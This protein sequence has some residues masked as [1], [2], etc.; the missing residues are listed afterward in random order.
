MERKNPRRRLYDYR[1][2]YANAADDQ[3]HWDG[4]CS[5]I[6]PCLVDQF[7]LLRLRLVYHCAEAIEIWNVFKGYRLIYLWKNYC[8]LIREIAFKYFSHLP[9]VAVPFAPLDANVL[10]K[11][12]VPSW[13]AHHRSR[14]PTDR[15]SRWWK[16]WTW[17]RSTLRK[18]SLTADNLIL[19]WD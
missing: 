12:D 15:Q 14:T 18:S 6:L 1:V 17:L 2:A 4:Q 10:D 9:Q 8:R 13:R 7:W 5:R 19:D 11:I 3:V 16:A